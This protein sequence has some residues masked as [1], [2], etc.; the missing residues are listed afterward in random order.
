MQ[1]LDPEKLNLISAQIASFLVCYTLFKLGYCIGLQKSILQPSQSVPYLGFDCDSRLQAFRLLPLKKQ[2]FISLVEAILD[3]SHVSITDLQI[4]AGKCMLMSMAVPGARLFTNEISMALSVPLRR[5][6]EHWLFL[7][8]A[9]GFF[10]WRLEQN[11]QFALFT[12]ASSYRWAGVLNPNAV[13]FCASDY[14]S[15]EILSSDIA[16][17]GVLALSRGCSLIFCFNYQG[18]KSRC[19]R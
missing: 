16:V 18:L 3:S 7:K 19:L 17:K 2:K 14:W 5:E 10:P 8:S 9:S 13:P 4:L 11:H 15:G 6:I 1:S 12:D